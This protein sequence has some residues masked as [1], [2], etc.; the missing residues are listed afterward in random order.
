MIDPPDVAVVIGAFGRQKYVAQAVDSV[1]AQTLPRA[2]Y[3]VVVIKDFSDEPLDRS[4]ASRG[5]TTILDAEP[6]I[7]RWLL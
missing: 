3:E 1:L 7:G 4:L 5:V 2:R 6:R